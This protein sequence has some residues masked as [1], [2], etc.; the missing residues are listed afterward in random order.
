MPFVRFTLPTAL[1]LSATATFAN[2]AKLEDVAPYPKAEDG[3]VRQVIHL[4]REV[5]EEN[6]KV[7]ILAGKTLT[8]DCNRQRLGGTLEEKTLEGWGYSYY[9]L[10]KVSGPASTLMACP[11]GKTRQDFVPVVGDGFVLRYNSKLPIVIYA[12]KDVEV[13]YRLWSASEKVEKAR[14][15]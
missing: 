9:R 13:R 15:E 1:L 5:Q 3:F 12:P 4:P 2:A 11:D 10:D 14:A 8:V 7:E 6:F